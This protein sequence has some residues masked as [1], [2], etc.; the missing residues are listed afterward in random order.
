MKVYI[1]L[2]FCYYICLRNFIRN[3]TLKC[4]LINSTTNDLMVRPT[5][6]PES[7]SAN[8]HS[9]LSSF[10][11]S[12]LSLVSA[13]CCF[14]SVFFSWLTVIATL[15]QVSVSTRKGTYSG[16][17]LCLDTDSTVPSLICEKCM[18]LF[19]DANNRY[20]LLSIPYLFF[21]YAPSSSTHRSAVL[22]LLNYERPAKLLSYVKEDRCPLPAIDTASR[23]GFGCK[24]RERVRARTFLR[25]P[26]ER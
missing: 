6:K 4:F 5:T 17:Y 3:E 20:L 2:Y 13:P 16:T 14:S 19:R 26:F 22:A 1:F 12:F 10:L 8:S 7:K 21:S 15:C 11:P 9:N 24:V 25:S 18:R 23:K